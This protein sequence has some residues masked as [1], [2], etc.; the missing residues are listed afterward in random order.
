LWYQYELESYL[1]SSFEL[2]L[3]LMYQYGEHWVPSTDNE[4]T[5]VDDEFQ[6]LQ[7]MLWVQLVHEHEA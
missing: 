7:C 2:F 1:S 5:V 6:V 3:C 4:T